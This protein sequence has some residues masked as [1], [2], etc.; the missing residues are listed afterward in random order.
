MEDPL[1]GL[2]ILGIMT[3][4]LTA[5]RVTDANNGFF[6]VYR[7][8]HLSHDLVHNVLS[9]TKGLRVG[10]LITFTVT[11]SIIGAYCII[12]LKSLLDSNHI[13]G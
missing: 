6:S 11:R 1:D 7:E 8:V 3:A 10:A 9:S 12:D 5:D 4:N 13:D 2:M